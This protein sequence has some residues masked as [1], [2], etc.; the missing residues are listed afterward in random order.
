MLSPL[1]YNCSHSEGIE[2]FIHEQPSAWRIAIEY[3]QEDSPAFS[4]L[5]F[6]AP[7]FEDAAEFADTLVRSKD[8]F[9]MVPTADN[10]SSFRA[11]FAGHWRCGTS[12]VKLELASEHAKLG[13]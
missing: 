9:A 11:T 12:D 10:G 2:V 7:T 8:M 6:R 4:L 3:R 1:R 13:L 5:R